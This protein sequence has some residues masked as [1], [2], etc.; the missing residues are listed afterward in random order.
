MPILKSYNL[1]MADYKENKNVYYA[2]PDNIA[3]LGGDD[4]LRELRESEFGIPFY[5]KRTSNEDMDFIKGMERLDESCETVNIILRQGGIVVILMDRFY[6]MI[7]YD[8]SEEYQRRAIDAIHDFA[9]SGKPHE[10]IL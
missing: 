2:Y 1:S 8:D 4:L 3:L 10:V 5:L 7:D 6:E 9:E